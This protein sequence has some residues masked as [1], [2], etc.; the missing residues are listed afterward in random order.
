MIKRINNYDIAI[1][2]ERV[3]NVNTVKTDTD[4]NYFAT[5]Q[6]TSEQSISSRSE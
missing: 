3:S 5:L 6:N 4:K 1:K 2:D